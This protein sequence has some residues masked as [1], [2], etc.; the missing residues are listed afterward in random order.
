MW[1][2]IK[3]YP[4]LKTIVV[5]ILGVLAFG[6][7]FNIMFGSGSSR[8]EGTMMESGYSLSDTLE[9]IIGLLIQFVIVAI[10]IGI[11]YWIVQ[12]IRKNIGNQ[13]DNKN[14]ILLKD[15]IIKNT[16]LISGS[17]VVL[18]IL[19]W[20]G[21]S[22]FYNS[23]N[24]FMMSNYYP[25]FSIVSIVIFFIKFFVLLL[26]IGLGISMIMY[27][28]NFSYS[29]TRKKDEGYNMNEKTTLECTDCH[30]SLKLEWKYCPNCG[31]DT[32]SNE[33]NPSGYGV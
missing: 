18:I 4:L 16:L 31:S 24:T 9:I 2:N 25:A 1:E 11:I 8:E 7:A 22:V 29:E 14:S 10:L 27:I 19:F 33:N 23:Y 32:T 30:S 28:K 21:K 12:T 15:P 3:K 13:Q 20:I 6:L 5:S 17:I 26:F